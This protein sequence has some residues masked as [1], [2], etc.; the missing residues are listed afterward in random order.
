MNDRLCFSFEQY[1]GVSSIKWFKRKQC[2][3]VFLL[4]LSSVLLFT[5]LHEVCLQGAATQLAIVCL[6]YYQWDS[7]AN[8]GRSS[9]Q[10]QVSNIKYRSVLFCL[11]K[12]QMRQEKVHIFLS[13]FPKT[14]SV[15][16]QCAISCLQIQ[17]VLLVI[18]GTSSPRVTYV[19]MCTHHVQDSGLR[20]CY[21]YY[22]L[23]C[24]A[25]VFKTGFFSCM[26]CHLW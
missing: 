3:S 7:T 23:C 9:H 4:P 25:C 6:S 11:F 24:E 22:L 5:A 18:N 14:G 12:R 8:P 17:S 26:L 19:I 21:L 16:P 2:L 20:G 13:T 15:M 1:W 10:I